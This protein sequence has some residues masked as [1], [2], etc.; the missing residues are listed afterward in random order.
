MLNTNSILVAAIVSIFLL[1]STVNAQLGGLF[2]RGPKIEEISALQVQ[3]AMK[4]QAAAEEKARK[5]GE[6]AP[7]P[8]FIL[9]DVRSEAEY[10]VSMIP[11]AI[12][13]AQYERDQKNYSGRTVIPY[14]TVGG[15]SGQYAA[16]LAAKGVKVQNFKGSILAWCEKQ[17]P[18]V[19]PKGD[20]TK[21]VHIY[22][23]RYQVPK[24]Y[25]P[26]W[27]K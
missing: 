2:G 23:S 12:T 4:D 24:I 6:P 1:P 17:L 10:S 22:S 16:K 11:G 19:T 13:K 20:A 7:N 26:V 18:L 25:D 9:V 21:R 27:S 14:C 5:S 15:R 8:T 3:K